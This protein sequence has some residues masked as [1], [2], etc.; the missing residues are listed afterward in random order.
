ML[1]ITESSFNDIEC[2]E[3]IKE[4]INKKI[5]VLEYTYGGESMPIPDNNDIK[6]ILHTP[7]VQQFIRQ[8]LNRNLIVMNEYELG[9]RIMQPYQL[10]LSRRHK[11]LTHQYQINGVSRRGVPTGWKNVDLRDVQSIKILNDKHFKIRDDYNPLNHNLFIQLWFALPKKNGQLPSWYSNIFNTTDYLSSQP[12]LSDTVI[13]NSLYTDKTKS[14]QQQIQN[15]Q[16]ITIYEF[17]NTNMIREGE[18][19]QLYLTENK[20]I[21]LLFYQT[22]GNK[23][24][25]EAIPGF[26]S[27]DLFNIQKIKSNNKQF[28]IRSIWN[29]VVFKQFPP[30][31]IFY[32]LPFYNNQYYPNYKS[33]YQVTDSIISPIQQKQI[34]NSPQ[35]NKIKQL[36][37][38]KK[39]QSIY[40]TDSKNQQKVIQTYQIFENK[41]KTN[42][43]ILGLQTEGFKYDNEK[44]TQ[45]PIWEYLPQTQIVRVEEYN[46]SLHLTYEKD[47]K[48]YNRNKI[49]L[50][51]SSQIFFEI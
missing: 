18:P 36:Q 38:Q 41:Q 33:Y 5:L 8:Q 51:F 7:K 20:R 27:I 37:N 15:K 4:Q 29:N 49:L 1:Q 16:I 44:N 42:I 43:F 23:S 10:Y 32:Q 35:L 21:N 39:Y 14:I 26:V 47:L 13:K 2:E 31:V 12:P 19:Y 17:S 22:Q 6:Q 9:T 3:V 25:T 50:P 45:F 48:M 46:P 28:Q 30:L 11:P 34:L 40:L 24:F